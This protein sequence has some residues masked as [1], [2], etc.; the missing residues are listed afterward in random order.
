[1]DARPK[2]HVWPEQVEHWPYARIREWQVSRLRD[3]AAQAHDIPFYRDLWSAAGLSASA[4]NSLDDMARFPIIN[5]RD[6]I[7]AGARWRDASAGRVAFSTRGTSGE[8]LLVWL[9]A[10]EQEIY[11]GPTMR[12]FRWAGFAPGQTALLMSP[13]W[14][15]LAAC[16]AHAI[17][18]LGGRCAFFWGSLGTEYMN[19]FVDTLTGLR[20][21]FVTT[22]APFLLAL[23]RRGEEHGQCLPDLFRS[24][25]S[26]VVVGLPLTSH[27]REYLRDKLGVEDVFERS[28]TQEGAALDDCRYHNTPHVHEDVCYLE[29]LDGHGHAVP[30]GQRGRLVVT[31][32][33]GAGSIFIRYDTGD[34]AGFA[35]EPCPCQCE[36]RRLKIFGRPESSVKVGTRLITAYDVRDCVERDPELIGRNILLVREPSPV[37]NVAIE[38]TPRD[39]EEAARRLRDHF[40]VE[41]VKI[42]WLGNL[43]VNWGFRQVVEAREIGLGGG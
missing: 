3:L 10:Q 28:G 29:V 43:R 31:K 36:F 39:G 23:V 9:G 4:I 11:I 41:D 6:L 26:I 42:S 5:K 14:H 34:I 20:P 7:K 19:A 24:V 33:T 40:A 13:V 21:A 15:R 22:T 1:M 17:I 18:R 12:G 8:P 27:I 2:S 25:R 37:L 32:L 38:G 16:E 35:P 30:P